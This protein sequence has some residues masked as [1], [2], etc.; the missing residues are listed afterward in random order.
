[1]GVVAR[2]D[3]RRTGRTRHDDP[4]LSPVVRMGPTTRCWPLGRQNARMTGAPPSAPSL[5]GS[6]GAPQLPVNDES[7]VQDDR[8]TCDA[9]LLE[10][11]GRPV[12]LRARPADPELPASIT[13]LVTT[14]V[15]V[16]T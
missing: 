5:R 1:M 13:F 10:M 14:L 16:A 9:R 7:G 6:I 3:I 15:I 8:S 2:G 4:P 11:S 12:W